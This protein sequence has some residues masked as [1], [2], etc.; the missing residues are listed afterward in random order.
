MPSRAAWRPDCSAGARSCCAGTLRRHGSPVERDWR[1]ARGL[2]AGPGGGAARH[3]GERAAQRVPNGAAAGRRR[4]LCPGARARP[5]RARRA[6]DPGRE[7]HR[8]VDARRSR[9]PPR[10]CARG[11]PAAAVDPGYR[12]GSGRGCHELATTREPLRCRWVVNAAGLGSDTVDRMF[13]GGGFTIRPRRG[14]LHRVRQA[15]QAAAPVDPAAGA[16]GADQRGARRAHGLRERAARPHRRGR[17]GPL[18][19]G[20][21]RCRAAV[22]ARGRAA[23]PARAGRRRGHLDLRRAAGRYRALRLSGPGGRRAAVRVRGWHPL[24]RP[25]RVAGDRRARGADCWRRPGW[26]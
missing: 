4:T 7:H 17:A 15:S 2:D 16:D 10:P 8:P 12:G 19:R 13:G 3:R 21:H 20:H 1:A 14:E 23:D 11:R 9:S 5:G 24:D 25:V 6:R 18:R 26:R 22:T